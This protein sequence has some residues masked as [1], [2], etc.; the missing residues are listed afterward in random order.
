VENLWSI[1][2]PE[3][4]GILSDKSGAEEALRNRRRVR[5][6][7]L[8]PAPVTDPAS[9]IIFTSNV[10][11]TLPPENIEIE[12]LNLGNHVK[13]YLAD[14][15][16]QEQM[17]W[18]DHPMEMG[19][20][21]ENSEF[22]YGL[23]GFGEAIRFEMERENGPFKTRPVMVMSVSVTHKG[24]QEFAAPYLEGL[25]KDTN[26]TDNLDLYL[27]TEKDTQEMVRD[28]LKPAA[29][30]FL[31][32]DG[33]DLMV[34]FGV[35]GE[36]GRHY[37]FLK[38]IALFWNILIDER[39]KATFK[40]DLDQLFP[41]DE[42]VKETGKSTFEHLKTN[43]W[44]ATGIDS[45]GAPVEL[46]MLAGALVNDDDITK[47]LFTPDVTYPS[48]ALKPDEMIFF[49]RLP[50]ALSTGAE[51]MT[52]YDKDSPINGMD[53]CI[54]RI[55]VTGGTTAILVEGLKKYRPFTPTFIGRAEDQAY[56][57][58]TLFNRPERLAYL[59]EA[60]LI[61]RHDKKSFAREEDMPTQISKLIGDFIR[62]LYFS[63]L[64]ELIP[65]GRKGVKGI[66]D[67]YTGCFISHIPI[68]VV[69]LRLAL[70]ALS[71]AH[72]GKSAWANDL[73]FSGARRLSA[74]IGFCSDKD[75]GLKG[76]YE[77]ER[78]AWRLF[79]DTMSVLDDSIRA[80]NPSG[81]E[82]RNKARD[83]VNRCMAKKG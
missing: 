13:E 33:S 36:Y 35:D 66:M 67:P 28:V 46:G 24:L 54:E 10:L 22:L 47:G 65:G 83:I 39:I 71:L 19:V 12:N 18:Y 49:S 44:G 51:M 55:H 52:K 26:L 11:I 32:R 56:I 15:M 40:I 34:I 37:S 57:L 82:L 76:Q 1:F 31:N 20:C 53:E 14:I 42:L 61:M 79:Y 75:N 30:G 6:T 60:G 25:L 16:K 4:C 80:L 9:E 45:Q 81:L 78:K 50:Q 70:K 64:S 41:Q 5:I 48:G 62:I 3:G 69:Y 27:F 68:T 23:E 59:H 21:R 58:S 77:K 63:A 17:Y 43:L 8:N 7:A 29:E 72:D 73:I 38:A 74:A 2:F